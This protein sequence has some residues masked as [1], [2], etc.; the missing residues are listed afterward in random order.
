MENQ[1][2]VTTSA[3]RRPTS[4]VS[5]VYCVALLA[6]TIYNIYLFIKQLDS[7]KAI[8]SAIL[9]NTDHPA[10]VQQL[11]DNLSGQKWIAVGV[12]FTAAVLVWAI[13]RHIGKY[14]KF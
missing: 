7:I 9:A 6:A 10:I 11:A 14:V 2:P 12:C 8:K 5:I 1:T 13:I 3:D 4:V